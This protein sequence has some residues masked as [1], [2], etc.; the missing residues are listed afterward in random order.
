MKEFW[1]KFGKSLLLPIST[2]AVAGIFSGLA[3]A[4]QNSAIVGETFANLVYV[5]NFI[6]FIRKLAGLVF[7]NL[8]LFFCMSIAIGMAKDEK[9]TAA[10]S[11]VLGFLVFHYTLNY[12]LGLK[13]IT[14]EST[15]ISKLMEQGMSQVDA[16][17][18]NAKYETMLG[19]FTLRMNV[20][21]GILV[22]LLV[23]VLHNR[24]Y[25]IT[26]PSAVNFFGG[27]R[28]VP[29]ITII[30]I[31]LA[32][33]ASYFIW[34]FFNTFIGLIGNWI[35]SIGVFGPFVYGAAN[36]LLIPT[37]LHHILN[38][39]VRFTPVGGTATIDGQTV[40]GALNIFNTAIASNSQVPNDVFQM[41]ARYVGQGHSLIVIFGL[42]AAAFA[43]YRSA[44]DKNKKRVKALL[45]ASVTASIL[46]GV[47]EPLEFS[48]M[49]I[50]P[51]LFLFH[52]IM[53][54]IGY[55]AAALLHCSVGGVQAGLID[56]TIFGIFR[57][58]QSKWYLV[59]LIGI[60]MAVIYYYGFTYLIQKFN[61]STPGRNEG[62]D[63]EDG[64]TA[65][66]NSGSGTKLAEQILEYLGGRENIGEIN[67]CFTRLR[68][69][70]KDMSLVQEH[71]LK[72]T[73]ASGIVCPSANQ[74][75]VIYGLKVESI[76][77]DV[78]ALYHAKHTGKD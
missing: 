19:Y 48:F 29:L 31:P 72:S 27:K 2:I 61:I 30:T 36:R 62:A 35:N 34:P 77:R 13:G 17:I 76:A 53:T 12:I 66:V 10:F 54:G 63:A 40:M 64:E 21:G 9:P 26:L 42:P 75:Q 69:T 58:A 57:G 5:Q 22:G 25:T 20:F 45:S 68:V 46:T 11:A 23:N 7:G 16:T 24:F 70:I 33:I 78:K 49:F 55:M 18:V 4:M 32:G 73:G 50:S 65:L 41:G 71:N 28:F 52:V 6:G 56:F 39:V 51:V 59:V 60:G 14:A 74:I 44:D 15:S 43:M 47:T 8:P 38:Q 3:A 67:N 1:Q 37:G